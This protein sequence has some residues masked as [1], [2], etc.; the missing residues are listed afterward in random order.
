MKYQCSKSLDSNTHST[1]SGISLSWC[2]VCD[3]YHQDVGEHEE[4]DGLPMGH[5]F[6]LV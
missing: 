1:S 3:V 4:R 5:D 2:Y 6:C